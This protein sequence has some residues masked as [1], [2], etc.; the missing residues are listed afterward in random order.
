MYV[1]SR[2]PVGA[3]DGPV[4]LKVTALRMP[5]WEPILAIAHVD[6]WKLP[7][8]HD[9][10]APGVMRLF[11]GEAS[12]TNIDP[13]RFTGGAPPHEGLV[14]QDIVAPGTAF[15]TV[16]AD[17]T[18]SECQPAVECFLTPI[19]HVGGFDRDRVGTLL[20]QEGG[21]RVYVWSVPDEVPVDSVYQ[22]ESTTAIEPRIDGCLP[23]QPDTCGFASLASTTVHGRFQA[24]AWQ[25]EVD[26]ELLKTLADAAPAPPADG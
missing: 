4:H 2:G 11:D 9:M 7:Q 23:D 3:F 20:L 12:V 25:G 24:F 21:R 16:V 8:L 19:L 1:G 5:G 26:L 22:E 10:P 17:T 13:M 18:A 6:H 15:L 14:L